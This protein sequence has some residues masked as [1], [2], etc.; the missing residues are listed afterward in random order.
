MKS[1]HIDWTLQGRP[2]ESGKRVRDRTMTMG[3]HG[4]GLPNLTIDLDHLTKT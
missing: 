1:G 2:L 3:N 4:G